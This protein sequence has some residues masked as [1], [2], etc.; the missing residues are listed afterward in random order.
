M[1][2]LAIG[3][4]NTA[5]QAY[6]WSEAVSR[7]LEISAWSFA[8]T[9]RSARRID[10]SAHH[11]IPHQR[12]RPRAIRK[13]RLQRLLRSRTHLLVESM[14][15]LFGDPHRALFNDELRLLQDREL[16][17]GAIFHGSDIRSPV[18]HMARLSNSFLSIVGRA[19]GS[20]RG[21]SR[22]QTQGIGD[23]GNSVVLSA[24]PTLSSTCQ[25]QPGFLS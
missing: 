11:R 7:E 6:Q 10:G 5:G 9:R 13:M 20:T 16:V 4:L 24:P 12:L 17:V 22:P 21:T 14:V 2:R 18:R 1:P 19:P 23:V 15:P 8:G 25:V 3:P